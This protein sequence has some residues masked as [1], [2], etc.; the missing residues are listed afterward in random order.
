MDQ[1]P[2]VGPNLTK[3]RHS[4]PH[5]SGHNHRERVVEDSPH[6]EEFDNAASDVENQKSTAKKNDNSPNFWM[7]AF[8]FAAIIIIVILIIWYFWKAR[9]ED[10]FNQSQ[11]PPPQPQQP[12]KRNRVEEVVND[13]GEQESEPKN[14]Q[15]ASKSTGGKNKKGEKKVKFSEENEFLSLMNKQKVD[16]DA[17]INKDEDDDDGG[18]DDN[19]GNDEGDEDGDSETASGILSDDDN[20]GEDEEVSISVPKY[21]RTVAKRKKN[22]EYAAKLTAETIS[23]K[24]LKLVKNN[25]SCKEFTRFLGTKE[26]K[27][28]L[29]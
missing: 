26:V 28:F 27:K 21:L 11:R 7:Y 3:T 29:N 23:L 13:D 6:E 12:Q 14:D 9:N 25:F 5:P 22:D 17:P 1:Y 19:G 8:A 10:K 18:E 24:D 16:L 15:R 20:D 2:T 4:K